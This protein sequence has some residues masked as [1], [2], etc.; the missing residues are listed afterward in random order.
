MR[1]TQLASRTVGVPLSADR[2]A[3][4]IAELLRRLHG[5]A[6][7]S[8]PRS[9]A[10]EDFETV[11]AAPRPYPGSY[12]LAD[13]TLAPVYQVGPSASLPAQPAEPAAG[14]T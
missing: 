7:S 5:A 6:D 3:L 13:S 10:L 1:A 4:V 11:D 14:V 2:G 12:V 8:L 9:V